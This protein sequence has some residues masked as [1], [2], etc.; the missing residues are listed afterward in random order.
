MQSVK[1]LIHSA[2]SIFAAKVIP[3]FGVK[4]TYFGK[5]VQVRL[6]ALFI[7]LR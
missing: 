4:F 5:Y 6:P 7:K 2:K 1:D 3:V